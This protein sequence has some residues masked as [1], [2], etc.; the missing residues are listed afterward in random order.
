M[1]QLMAITTAGVLTLALSVLAFQGIDQASA[2]PAPTAGG[3]ASCCTEGGCFDSAVCGDEDTLCPAGPD[4][5]AP[6]VCP[7]EDMICP[8]DEPAAAQVAEEACTSACCSTKATD[9]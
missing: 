4:C 5:F 8:A 9:A 1:K 3:E 7:D 2:S 6:D